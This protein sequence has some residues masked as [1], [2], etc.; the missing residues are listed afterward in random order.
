M[1]LTKKFLDGLT[2]D[3]IGCAIEVHR[4][5]GPGLLESVY[6]KCFLRELEL[7]NIT[8]RNQLSVPLEY[9]GLILEGDLRCDVLVEEL[10][11]VELKAID[12]ILPVHEAVL[13]SYMQMLQKPK[14]I[15]IN[16][17]CKNIFKSGQRT[18]VNQYFSAL[19]KDLF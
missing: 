9:K 5:L 11:V 14:G 6:E 3:I 10:I 12:G 15:M 4:I 16:F 1:L 18:F 2:Y 17:K 13:L 19:P 8:Y 7:R